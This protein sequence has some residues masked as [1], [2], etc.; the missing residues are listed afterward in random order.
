MHL[1]AGDVPNNLGSGD[2]QKWDPYLPAAR[3]ADTP[4]PPILRLVPSGQPHTNPL[5]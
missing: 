3:S 4:H 2:R 1:L 5:E